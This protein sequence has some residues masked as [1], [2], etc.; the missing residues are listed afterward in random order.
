M[1]TILTMIIIFTAAGGEM[2]EDEYLP[3][4]STEDMALLSQVSDL[5][6]ETRRSSDSITAKG[7][8]H[9]MIEKF[10]KS[11]VN[12]EKFIQKVKKT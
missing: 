5:H 8:N 6:Q 1:W 4:T 3:E 9:F 7:K 11:F 12:L 10:L 2:S